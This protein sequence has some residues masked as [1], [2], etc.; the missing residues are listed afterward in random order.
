ME[1][2]GKYLSGFD[3]LSLPVLTRELGLETGVRIGGWEEGG[4]GDFVKSWR[5]GEQLSF[6]C[7]SLFCWRV[8][9]AHFVHGFFSSEEG[10]GLAATLSMSQWES[11]CPCHAATPYLPVQIVIPV[12]QASQSVISLFCETESHYIVKAGLKLRG[13]GNGSAIESTHPSSGR[14]RL[15]HSTHPV[16]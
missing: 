5:T 7:L 8:S 15:I 10:S 12:H 16:V 3:L 9:C 2:T 4:T 6:S 13:W 1:W 11:L 14:L